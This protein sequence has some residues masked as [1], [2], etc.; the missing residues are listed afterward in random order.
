MSRHDLRGDPKREGEGD[1]FLFMNVPVARLFAWF[2][3]VVRHRLSA[4]ATVLV[5][6]LI[7]AVAA[8]AQTL[9]YQSVLSFG[10]PGLDGKRPGGVI[11]ADDGL[12]Y[13]TSLQGGVSNVG[14]IFRLNQ[15]GSG[16]TNLHTFGVST[17]DGQSPMAIVQGTNGAIY[18]TTSIGGTNNLGT[19]FTM[20]KAGSGY[21]VLYSFGSLPDAA[22]PQ[23]GLIQG[24]DGFLYG[25]TEFGGS[26]N[27]G[28]VYRLGADGSNYAILHHFRGA[29]A[30]GSAPDA[31][32]VQGSD[33]WLYGTSSL[34]GTN[35][36]G[37]VFK[38]NTNGS[39]YF[40]LYSFSG[41]AGD[42]QNPDTE[43]IQGSD[44]VL[45]G[46]THFGGSNNVGT[47]FK[48]NTNGSSYAVLHTFSSTGGD[49]QIPLAGLMEGAGGLLYSTTYLGGSGGA[50]AIF[51]L[52]K[53]GTGYAILHSFNTD[54]VDGQNARAG[55]LQ[56]RDLSLF[57]TTWHGGQSGIGTVYRFLPL[58][59]P[60]MLA[61]IPAGSSAQVL[62]TGV[63]GNVYNVYRSTNLVSWTLSGNLTMPVSGIGTN[64]DSISGL[65]A[66]FYR[67]AWLP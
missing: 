47:I 55:I 15:D 20:N 25:T 35:D 58:A 59:T 8:S 1:D 42:G 27:L 21:R 26:N 38:L 54:G 66:A 18:G 63:S 52:N 39:G 9:Q 28:T 24:R 61:V 48:I 43:L 11:Q 2:G 10:S 46:T 37:S 57:G 16:A 33:G 56:G 64:V 65:R 44:G 45:Y 12:L 36:A 40:V 7:L 51:Q 19:V 53:A 50:G 6:S 31:A 13:G 49:G 32:V 60:Q 23:A 22:N 17:N 62:F 41:V 3:L 29:S 67:A 14:T 5:P 4:F 30:D 34:G